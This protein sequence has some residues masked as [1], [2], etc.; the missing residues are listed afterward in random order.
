[1]P[2]DTDVLHAPTPT[3]E[4]LSLPARLIATLPVEPSRRRVRPGPA[5]DHVLAAAARAYPRLL[6]GASDELARPKAVPLPRFPLSEVDEQLRQPV[7]AE[8][9]T[10]RWLA[11]ALDGRLLAPA[12]ARLLPVPSKELA[13]SVATY[14]PGLVKAE[15]V[16]HAAALAALDVVQAA[17][18]PMWSISSP[19]SAARQRN[20]ANS[21]TRSPRS[22]TTTRQR[23]TT[24]A[25]CRFRSST[26]A[27]CPGRVA[28]SSRTSICPVWT[29]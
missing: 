9:R 29:V 17:D 22:S 3:D 7:L 20:G 13:E 8:L 2:R 11:P 27:R 12:E 5:A 1:M 15:L 21:T 26:A 25:R 23:S 4:R 10:A 16:E 18:C 24:S 14:V 19:G 6:D 28:C